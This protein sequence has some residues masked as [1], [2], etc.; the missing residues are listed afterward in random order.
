MTQLPSSRADFVCTPDG[1]G[2][3]VDYVGAHPLGVCLLADGRGEAELRRWTVARGDAP[4]VAPYRERL[5][6]AV[7]GLTGQNR[8]GPFPST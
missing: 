7:S 1:A 2:T 3:P 8:P 5:P 6:T 4:V